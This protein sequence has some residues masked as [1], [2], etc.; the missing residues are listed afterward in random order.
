MSR[1]KS[2]RPLSVAAKPAGSPGS[3]GRRRFDAHTA[4]RTRGDSFANNATGVGTQHDPTRAVQFCLELLHPEYALELYRGNDIAQKVVEYKV[5]AAFR[6][7]YKINTRDNEIS[8]KICAALEDLGTSA[9]M[10]QAGFWERVIGGASIFPV[11]NDGADLSEPLQP[12]RMVEIENLLVLDA[13]E[14][15]PVSYYRSIFDKDRFTKKSKFGHPMRFRFEPRNV[16]A[17]ALERGQLI[18]ESRLILFPGVKV[19]RDQV[20]YL[21]WWGDSALTRPNRVIEQFS[22][23]WDGVSALM[24]RIEQGVLAMD[25]FSDAM[26]EDDNSAVYD[27]LIELNRMRNLLDMLVID[28]NDKYER[29]GVPLTG[30]PDTLEKFLMRLAAACEMPGVFLAGMSPSGLN[31]TGDAEIRSWYDSVAEEQTDH[32]GPRLEQLVRMYLLTNTSVTKGKEPDV[33]SAGWEPLW[34]PTAK[35]TAETNYTQAQADDLNIQNGVLTSTI[36]R[37]NRFAGD[38]ASL[39]TTVT[40]AEMAELEQL[41]EANAEA[42]ATAAAAGNVPAGMPGVPA[43]ADPNAPA[44]DPAL[45]AA[46]PTATGPNATG[47]NADR[48][49]ELSPEDRAFVEAIVGATLRYRKRDTY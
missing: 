3:A 10:R 24:T 43:P 7:G 28:K 27:A 11:I 21:E 46:S 5:K 44:R 23:T 40:P 22:Q 4:A 18:H 29:I 9:A 17:N 2:K 12:G 33:W 45:T 48:L 39:A 35:E 6:E 16:R 8:E 30:V 41:G 1:K 36:V 47:P 42:I 31:S 37:R 20:G 49:D 38:T 13:R 32:F 25:G 34:Q 15:R 14:L 26:K 19:T